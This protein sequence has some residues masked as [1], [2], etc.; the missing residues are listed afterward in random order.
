M[1]PRF[2]AHLSDTSINYVMSQSLICAIEYEQTD[3]A[4]RILDRWPDAMNAYGTDDMF[5]LNAAALKGNLT[6]VLRMFEYPQLDVHSIDGYGYNGLLNALNPHLIDTLHD[7]NERIDVSDEHIEVAKA[8]LRNTKFNHLH[9][10]YDG[11]G[12]ALEYVYHERSKN[13][14][15]PW[16]KVLQIF[17]IEA[18]EAEISQSND[19]NFKEFLLNHLKES[20]SLCVRE[21]LSLRNALF[22]RLNQDILIPIIVWICWNRLHGRTEREKIADVMRIFHRVDAKPDKSSNNSR[23]RLHESMDSE[24]P[25]RNSESLQIKLNE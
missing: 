8:F 23:I 17:D 21:V 25:M 6:L 7:S 2:T 24:N 18:L 9:I 1:N 12:T 4:S 15:Y 22:C 13:K 20:R 5:P 10:E 14:S 11:D 19:S 3:V 16:W